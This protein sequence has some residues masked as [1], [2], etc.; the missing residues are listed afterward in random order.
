[1]LVVSPHE[2][3]G[4]PYCH[5]EALQLSNCESRRP[6]LGTNECN[7]DSDLGTPAPSI[8]GTQRSMGHEG[9]SE[10]STVSHSAQDD[11]MQALAETTAIDSSIIANLGIYAVPAA[12]LRCLGKGN[13]TFGLFLLIHRYR[14]CF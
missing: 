1:M 6:S 8:P 7:E 5:D 12:V 4:A 14:D 9:A 11:G 10:E 3:K 2:R 13:R